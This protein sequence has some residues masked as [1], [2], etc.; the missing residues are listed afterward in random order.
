MS[1]SYDNVLQRKDKRAAAVCYSKERKN[2]R[3][4]KD[5]YNVVFSVK[6]KELLLEEHMECSCQE[7]ERNKNS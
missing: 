3:K 1:S 4:S 5:I 2:P 7:T 6:M